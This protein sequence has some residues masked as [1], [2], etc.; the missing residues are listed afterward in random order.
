MQRLG[1]VA[2]LDFEIIELKQQFC[3]NTQ[4]DRQTDRQ[5]DGQTDKLS[6]VPSAHAGE[7][8]ELVACH[9]LPRNAKNEPN[10]SI[11]NLGQAE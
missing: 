5:T 6:T 1:A 3:D 7:G 2:G 11:Y 8:N 9:S 4:T 10:D